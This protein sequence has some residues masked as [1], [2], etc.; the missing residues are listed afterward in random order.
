MV[1]IRNKPREILDV[2]KWNKMDTNAIPTLYL[3]LA[4]EVL[5]S[6]AEKKKVK[7]IWDMLTK[8]YV[9]NHKII[10]FS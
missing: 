1:V 2:Y 3:A 5:S 9:P 10:K 6:V 4:D 8:V 7:E